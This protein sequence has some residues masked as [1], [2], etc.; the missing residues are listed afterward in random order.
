MRVQ[1]RD[2]FD[3]EGTEVFT[4]DL[5]APSANATI[6]RSSATATIIDND[7]PSGTPLASIGDFVVD[8]AAGTA[9][10]VI[11]LDQPSLGVVSI[12]YATQNGTAH[13][14][15]DYVAA[16]GTLNFAPGETAKTVKVAAD[17][18]RGSTKALRRSAWRSRALS[19]RPCSIPLAQR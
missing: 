11:T 10:F 18:R 9:N 13:A 16:S 8:E 4:M 7:A 2:D 14:G 15:S 17:Q 1:L 12:N 5:S 19:E 6:A 3:P